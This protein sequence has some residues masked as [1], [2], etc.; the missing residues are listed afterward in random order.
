MLRTF[1]IWLENKPGALMRVT[2]VVTANGANIEALRMEPDPE[3]A[4]YALITMTAEIAPWNEERVLKEISRL[5]EVVVAEEV[6]EPPR[7]ARERYG[8]G[9]KAAVNV[10]SSG[11][12]NRV[13]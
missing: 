4:A 3:E 11:T 2:R 1:R 6:A 12:S 5:D 8:A 10:S 9:R 13:N 7:G